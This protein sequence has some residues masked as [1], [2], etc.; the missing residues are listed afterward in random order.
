MDNTSI[1]LNDKDSNISKQSHDESQEE[2]EQ[3]TQ[4]VDINSIEINDENTALNVMVSYMNLAQR[5]GVFNM[6][7]SAKLWECIQFFVKK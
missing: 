5:R 4:K 1:E 2:S 3:K 7:E 6:Q